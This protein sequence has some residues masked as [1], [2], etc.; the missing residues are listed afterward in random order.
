[1]AAERAAKTRSH[2]A[3]GASP[4][5]GDGILAIAYDLTVRC[6]APEDARETA[7]E[8]WSQELASI[9]RTS[10]IQR[11]SSVCFARFRLRPRSLRLP[12]LWIAVRPTLIQDGYVYPHSQRL[13]AVR[14]ARRHNGGFDRRNSAVVG[15]RPLESFIGGGVTS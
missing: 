5:A 9:G 6:T 14:E 4:E 3:G 2:R 13:R 10:H 11:D 12:L 8:D 7:L 15:T 1:M